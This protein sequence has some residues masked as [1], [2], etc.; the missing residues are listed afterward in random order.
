MA[1]TKVAPTAINAMR[2]ACR[3]FCSVIELF[4][5]HRGFST[6]RKRPGHMERDQA[7][8]PSATAAP[9]GDVAATR[10]TIAGPALAGVRQAGS[11][12]ILSEVAA[13]GMACR[14][15]ACR[16]ASPDASGRQCP[17]NAI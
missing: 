12:F 5:L 1:K 16:H 15:I 10:R 9:G 11:I 2:S 6:P 4:L 3:R 13:I 14:R 7:V 17:S 8:L